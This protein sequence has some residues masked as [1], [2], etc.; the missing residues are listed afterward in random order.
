[1]VTEYAD[2]G[3]TQAQQ[4]S[5][6]FLVINSQYSPGYSTSF[7]PAACGLCILV[8]AIVCALPRAEGDILCINN[9]RVFLHWGWLCNTLEKK[10][11]M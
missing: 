10:N 2:E 7:A 8:F 1:M 6:I 5:I 3:R 9:F 4:R 11:A